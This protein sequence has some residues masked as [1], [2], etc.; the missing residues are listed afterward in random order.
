MFVSGVFKSFKM[1]CSVQMDN[2]ETLRGA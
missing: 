1:V 2:G